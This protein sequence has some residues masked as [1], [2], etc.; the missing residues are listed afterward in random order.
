MIPANAMAET[1]AKLQQDNESMFLQIQKNNEVIEQLY[2]LT[3]WT[4]DL[5]QNP[6]VLEES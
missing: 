4:E 5:E 3:E 6:I 1:V 2:S